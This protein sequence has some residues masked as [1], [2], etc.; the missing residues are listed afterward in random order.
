MFEI[1]E[2]EI[3][4]ESTGCQKIC[5]KKIEQISELFKNK[6]LVDLEQFLDELFE[7]SEEEHPT[8][9]EILQQEELTE[10]LDNC[11]LQLPSD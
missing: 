7:S 5:L 6:A 10:T 4:V 11:I 1:I 9:V 2:S 8:L 3:I